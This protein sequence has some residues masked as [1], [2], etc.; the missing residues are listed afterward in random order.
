MA[1]SILVPNFG[2]ILIRDGVGV[3]LQHK[4]P[5]GHRVMSMRS[6]ASGDQRMRS[7]QSAYLLSLWAWENRDLETGKQ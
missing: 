2:D 1:F 4:C 3:T 6:S 7:R 5:L